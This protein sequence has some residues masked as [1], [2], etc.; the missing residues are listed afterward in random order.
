MYKLYSYILTLNSFSSESCIVKLYL[1]PANKVECCYVYVRNRGGNVSSSNCVL[2]QCLG[3][4]VINVATYFALGRRCHVTWCG[5]T[6]RQTADM[7]PENVTCEY[8]ETVAS[9]SISCVL[10]CA[11][12]DPRRVTCHGQFPRR[13]WRRGDVRHFTRDYLLAELRRTRGVSS[14][15][16]GAMSH[17]TGGSHLIHR[18]SRVTSN[19]F[20]RL[21]VS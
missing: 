17:S 14:H 7:L 10:G 11:R 3:P 4:D 8:N 21:F 6:V 13:A 16:A 5:E 2:Y 20:V 12:H 18:S 15:G 9:S 19:S 1:G